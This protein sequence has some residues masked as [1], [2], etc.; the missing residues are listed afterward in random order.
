MTFKKIV[1]FIDQYLGLSTTDH[2]LNLFLKMTLVL[3]LLYMNETI[4][5]RV[6]M[7]VVLVPG[8]LFHKILNNKYY[9]LALTG[10]VCFVYLILDLVIY[11]PNHK[12]VYAY[13]LLGITASFFMKDRVGIF[14]NIRHQSKVI[15][16]LCF[17]F[18]TAGKFL[19]PEFLDA[20]FF[21]FTLSTDARFFGILSLIGDLSKDQLLL[22]ES[23]LK[24]LVGGSMNPSDSFAI[25]VPSNIM[26]I[27]HFLTYWTIFLEGLIGISFLLPKR[28]LLS[29]YRNILL[30]VFM[31]TTYPIATVA[32][33]AIVLALLGF[34]QSTEDGRLTHFSYFFLLVF[35]LLPLINTP[36]SQIF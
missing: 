11:V 7:P 1:S 24:N 13:A 30:V 12:H 27:A 31:V 25:L 22:N 18:A 17:L 35:I 19:A 8:I 16:G 23:N 4:Y 28:F 15:I 32:G 33:F 26:E 21:K 3:L 14:S 36:F 34:M 29:K 20:S 2:I 6:F 5:L 9:W 10:I